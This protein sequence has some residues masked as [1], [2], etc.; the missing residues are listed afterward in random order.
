MKRSWLAAAVTLAALWPAVAQ[1]D[2]ELFVTY[3]G[4]NPSGNN[5]WQ[6]AVAPDPTFFSNTTSGFGSSLAVELAFAVTGSTI[7]SIQVNNVDWDVATPG[8]NPFTNTVTFGT[9][10]SPENDKA[11]TSYGSRVFLSGDPVELFTMVTLGS[12]VTTIDY[13]VA[14]SGDGIKGA[15]IAQSGQ[16]FTTGLTLSE[17]A[18]LSGSTSGAGGGSGGPGTM[19]FYG[20][21]G[22]ITAPEPATAWLMAAGL[23]VGMLAGRRRGK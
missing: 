2:P 18:A 22:S 6:V 7:Q 16:N 15:T 14:A 10:I 13:G 9:R 17:L 3:D 11:F 20:F 19:F 4:L 8:N 23:V 5:Q 1:A 21:T 12:V